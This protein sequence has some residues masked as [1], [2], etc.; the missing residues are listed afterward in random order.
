MRRRLVILIFGLQLLGCAAIP[1]TPKPDPV[2]AAGDGMAGVV[3]HTHSAQR[4]VENAIPHADTTGKT[5]LTAASDE[6]QEVFVSAA[7]VKSALIEA[8]VQARQ[9]TEV[10][11][12][13]RHAHELLQAKWY[14]VWGR[15]IERLLWV[16]GIAWLILGIAS[17]VLGIGN[18]L[19]WTQ[20]LGKEIVRFVP[21]MN[22]FSWLRDWIN[23]RRG[24]S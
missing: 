4:H 23:T 5:Y 13:Q 19:S 20:W 7:A 10:L 18:P 21:L 6:H 16:V 12:N 2:G 22:P 11:A 3:A 1:S 14:V 15:R 24:N 17:V 8:Q 9:Q